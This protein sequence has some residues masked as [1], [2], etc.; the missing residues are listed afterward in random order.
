LPD[1]V[2]IARKWLEGRFEGLVIETL[3]PRLNVDERKGFAIVSG[4][5]SDR[6]GRKHG[7]SFLLNIDG[8]VVSDRSRLLEKRDYTHP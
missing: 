5:V 8:T 7:F 4:F 3:R 1:Y 2:A 6:E